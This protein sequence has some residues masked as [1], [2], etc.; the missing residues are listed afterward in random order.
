[1]QPHMAPAT[2]PPRK[3]SIQTI[4]AGIVSVGIVSA[5]YSVAVV[6]IRYCPGAPMLNRPVLK[7]TATESPVIISGVPL[8][9][10]L[11]MLT[12][13]KPKVS[14][15]ASRPVLKSPRNTSLTPSNIPLVVMPSFVSPTMI[16]IRV[17]TTMPM[18]MEIIAESIL[19]KASVE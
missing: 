9:S 14:A 6:P 15:P 13:L 10:M 17:P 19:L 11:P 8:K 3:A 1:M 18:R 5:I 4:Q 12:G 7:A 2:I 16:T